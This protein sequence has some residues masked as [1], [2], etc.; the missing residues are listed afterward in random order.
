MDFGTP[1]WIDAVMGRIESRL[2]AG[3]VLPASRVFPFLGDP[4]DLL[5]KPP[6]E[7]FITISPLSF[8]VDNAVVTGA[9]A[10]D[11]PLDGQI[12]VDVYARSGMDR[13]QV[14]RRAFQSRD[15]SLSKIVKRVCD[16]LQLATLHTQISGRDVSALTHPMRLHSITF[17]PRRLPHGWISARTV[18]HAPFRVTFGA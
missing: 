4:S 1:H 8:V 14:D 9:G 12:A 3:D 18:W 17:N 2:V 13:Q 5:D 6:G 11:T 15:E 16:A 7:Q 10:P